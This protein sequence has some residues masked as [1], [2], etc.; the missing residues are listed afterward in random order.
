MLNIQRSKKIQLTKSYFSESPPVLAESP[1]PLPPPRPRLNTQ[2]EINRAYTNPESISSKKRKRN[3]FETVF[4]RPK[5]MQK[6]KP[7]KPKDLTTKPESPLLELI[8]S[9]RMSFSSPDLSKVEVNHYV[10]EF[11]SDLMARS[12]ATEFSI[13]NEHS[14]LNSTTSS[15][16]QFDE[17]RNISENILSTFN[18][19]CNDSTVNLVGSKFGNTQKTQVAT[20][21]DDQ[22][23]YCQMA[24]IIRNDRP[25]SPVTIKE[26]PL[27]SPC[28][29]ANKNQQRIPVDVTKTITFC[30]GD[31]GVESSIQNFENLTISKKSNHRSQK[32][33]KVIAAPS[34]TDQCK[35]SVDSPKKCKHK[36]DSFD[37]KYPS[38]YP[39]DV[40]KT[41][42]KDY[43]KTDGINYLPKVS[44]TPERTE[45]LYIAT[46]RHG[47]SIHRTKSSNESPQLVVLSPTNSLVTLDT[48]HLLTPLIK[49]SMSNTISSA[50]PLLYQKYATVTPIK[51]SDS[52]SC[53]KGSDISISMKRFSS[54]PRFKKIDFSPLKLKINSV[55]QRQNPDQM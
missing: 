41:P 39:N 50:S 33:T 21:I 20:I 49:S 4:S 35:I 11:E 46:P 7:A 32:D 23:G 17:E 38:Y 6:R 2:T 18:I 54:L 19:E 26:L 1:P 40:Q 13:R 47:T 5:S 48:S 28:N 22:S 27:K 30:R 15:E 34:P 42:L 14:F 3:I 37:E 12:S 9:H 36:N 45:N 16:K 25:N 51:V 24:P 8:R 55:L 29:V 52:S 53:K 43:H 44:N 31:Y 10:N